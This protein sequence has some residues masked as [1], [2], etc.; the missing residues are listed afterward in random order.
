MDTTPDS[1]TY[2]FCAVDYIL[3]LCLH[4]VICETMRTIC[5][6]RT[7][8]KANEAASEEAPN[9]VPST[10]NLIAFYLYTHST[11]IYLAPAICQALF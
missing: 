9:T 1:V 5:S 8:R 7:L 3:F 11:C 6:D 2:Q 10:T 4:V